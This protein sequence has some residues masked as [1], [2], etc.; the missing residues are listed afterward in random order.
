MNLEKKKHWLY[1]RHE[2][3]EKSGN[4]PSKDSANSGYKQTKL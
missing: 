4:H 2:D 3:V 1:N